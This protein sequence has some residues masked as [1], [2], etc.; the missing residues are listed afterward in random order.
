MA[1]IGDIKSAWQLEIETNFGFR[2]ANAVVNVI[3]SMLIKEALF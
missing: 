3:N 1:T 2:Q